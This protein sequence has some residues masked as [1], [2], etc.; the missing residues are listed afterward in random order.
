MKLSFTFTALAAVASAFPAIDTSNEAAFL[1]AAK[2][3]ART[4]KILEAEDAQA[5]KAAQNVRRSSLPLP[6]DAL[7][8]SRAETNCGPTIPCPAFDA[9]DQYVSIEGE[10]AY[11]APAEDEIR[12][13]C[14][15]L[16]AAA[17]H[18]Y[19]PRSGVASIEETVRGMNKLY[20]MGI[21]LA[22]ALAAYA[23]VIDGD[24]LGGTWSIGG[25]QQS[26]P[27]VPILGN[28]QGL[29]YS[30][31]SYEG[32][33]SIGRLDAFTNNG[34]AH[35]LSI[36]KFEA[37]YAVGGNDTSENGFD[38]RYTIDKFRS[39]FEEVQQHSIDTNPYYFTG[40]FSTVVVVPAAYNFVINFMSNHSEEHPSGYLDGYNFKQFFGVTGTPGSF[41]W[42]RGQE[43]IPENWYKRPTIS[44]YNLADVFVD[45]GIGYLAYP[46]TLKI[47]G[48]TGKVN[49]FTGVNVEDLTSGV[50]NAKNLFEGDNFACFAFVLLQ[51]G[52][53]HFLKGPLEDIN[54]ATSFLAPFL[55]PLLG[56]LT[57]PELGKFDQSLFNS[58]PGH[59]YSPTGPATNY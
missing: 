40:A 43:R 18:G 41:K 34:D 49:S 44:P 56:K 16:N 4:V 53:P 13:P 50:L 23:I 33:S 59:K 42:Q 19:L 22:A 45:V 9:E 38:Q 57:C 24:L 31:N 6:Q 39:R 8:I 26:D 2:L 7:G 3:A 29:S 48:N 35:S 17:N 1:K 28:G 25:P 11:A 37:V 58:F 46:N 21:D 27:L 32:D 15:G 20:N 12:G 30:H 10:H 54:N 55:E 52:I 36:E 51:Q 47:G 14:P 5:A